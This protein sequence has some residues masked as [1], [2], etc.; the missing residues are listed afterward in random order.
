MTSGGVEFD[1]HGTRLSLL[2]DRAVWLPEHRTVLV[3]D[4]HLGKPASFRAMGV[5]VPEAVTDRDLGRMSALLH[6]TGACRLIVLG[7]LVH[8]QTAMLARTCD[9][10]R[11]WRHE[12]PGV[13]I[14]LIPG[15]HDR[16]ATACERLGVRVLEPAIELGGLRL[17]H[18]PPPPGTTPAPPTAPTLCGHLHPVVSVGGHRNVA[19]VR[20][21]CFW[22][23]GP[24]GI[25]PAFGSFTGGLA[26]AMDPGQAVFAA[27]DRAVLPVTPEASSWVAPEPSG[28]SAFA[29]DRP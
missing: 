11:A 7:D 3:A 13:E 28:A 26:M 18:E 2:P 16:R 14:D 24:V 19:R 9:A 10:A 6:A 17:T 22:F 23:D 1:W 27:G 21:P 8:D 5:P 4:V 29:Y 20:T 12:W 25:L 15:N